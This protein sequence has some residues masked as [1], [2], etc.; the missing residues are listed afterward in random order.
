MKTTNIPTVASTAGALNYHAMRSAMGQTSYTT[1]QAAKHLTRRGLKWRD[2]DNDGKVDL[3]YTLDARFTSDQKARIRES[4]KSWAEVTNVTFK[5]NAQGRDGSLNISAIPGFGGGVAS[6][7]TGNSVGSVNIGTGGA[8]GK[9]EHGTQFDLVAV[10][11]LGHALGLE[12]PHGAGPSYQEDSTAYT[13]MSYRNA[14]FGDHPYN[15]KKIAAPMLHDIAA[16]Q[17]LYGANTDT[18]KTNTIY[19]FNSNTGRDFYSLESAKDKPIFNVWDSGG[20][21][22]LDFSGFRQNQKIN[23]NAE[24]FS[25]VGGM[26]NN[27]SIAKGVTVENAVGGSGDDTLIGNEV[28][29]RLKGGNGADRLEGG[30]GADVF[31]FE[32][33]AD[34]TPESPDQILDFVSGTDKI[35]LY[36]LLNRAALKHLYVVD[37]FTGRAGDA[38]LSYNESTA[39]GSL[40]IDMTGN[41]KPD[42]QV[43]SKGKIHYMDLLVT[44]EPAIPI[45]PTP[46]SSK[47]TPTATDPTP[48]STS[49][50]P[51]TKREGDTKDA[52][53]GKTHTYNSASESNCR[54]FDTLDDFI[55]GKDKLDISNMAAKSGVTLTQVERFSGRA[56]E[57]YIRKSYEDDRYWVA[58]DLDGDQYTDFLVN[59]P[60]VIRAGDIVGMKLNSAYYR[61]LSSRT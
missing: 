37:S 6:L 23:L 3:S 28:G 14:S 50:T 25:D 31:V 33:V 45:E 16:V 27:V 35:G 47:G 21:D 57:V 2:K 4:L 39:E 19:G 44:P 18:R 59:S 15:G 22:T 29:N 46:T 7:P 51:R 38:V 34:S 8:D 55:S 41:G 1:D 11:E 12:H 43:K 54:K 40:S 49:D 36:E 53:D 48:P 56:G 52:R 20:I 10:H 9:L 61:S 26:N 58:V 60:K 32:G 24:S 17:R 30:G 42:F 5:E 13:A